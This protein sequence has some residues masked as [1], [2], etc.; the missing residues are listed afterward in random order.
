MS[1]AFKSDYLTVKAI[2][3]EEVVVNLGFTTVNL[4]ENVYFPFVKA[5]ASTL[6]PY[7]F[8]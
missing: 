4:A 8:T 3:F 2:S 5:G 6:S 1:E 7:S